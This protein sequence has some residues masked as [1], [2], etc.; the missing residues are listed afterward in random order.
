[1][2]S[3]PNP[4]NPLECADPRFAPLTPLESADLK[5]LDLKS[6]G[7]NRSKKGGGGGVR[8]VSL[9]HKAAGCGRAPSIRGWTPS[10]PSRN[11]GLTGRLFVAQGYN[12]INSGRTKSWNVTGDERHE[13]QHHR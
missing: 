9:R 6:F 4:L 7:M 5:L 12:W 10:L 11:F 13:Q 3:S 8:Y 1:M 2:N